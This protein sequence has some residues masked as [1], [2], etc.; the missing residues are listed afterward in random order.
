LI[1]SSTNSAATN[2]ECRANILDCTLESRYR[3]R[4]RLALNLREGVI[5]NLLCSR[6][7]ALNKNL[8]Y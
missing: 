3:I 6:A 1:G 5:D 4:A 2:L 7:L 8:V